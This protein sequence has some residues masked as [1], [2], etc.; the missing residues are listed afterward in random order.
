MEKLPKQDPYILLGDLNVN[1]RY[2]PDNRAVAVATTVA[3][4][5]LVDML[6]H[7]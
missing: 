4:F 1:L 5:G 6:G 3:S 7:F 2:P